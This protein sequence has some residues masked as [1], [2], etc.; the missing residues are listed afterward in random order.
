MSTKLGMTRTRSARRGPHLG[1]DVVA[2]VVAEHR[3]RG[4]A[5]VADP[6]EPPR[7]GDDAAVGDRP[8]LDRRVG[9]DVLDVEH[10]RPAADEV[11]QPSR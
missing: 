6:L 9:E 10:Q 2:Q 5:V 11:R 4:G 3:D 8:G 1:D 7:D